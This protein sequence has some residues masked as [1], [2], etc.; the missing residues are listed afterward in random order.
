MDDRFLHLSTV[1]LQALVDKVGKRE[2]QH[3]KRPGLNRLPKRIAAAV[4]AEVELF[5]R[6]HE[7][8][9]ANERTFERNFEAGLF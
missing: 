4:G 1:E 9:T 5:R 2:K 7:K 6:A 3:Q 8:A